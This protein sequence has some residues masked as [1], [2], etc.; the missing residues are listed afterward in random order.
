MGVIRKSVFTSYLLTCFIFLNNFSFCIEI[1]PSK[2][3]R[4]ETLSMT[5]VLVFSRN[6][7]SLRV[8]PNYQLA[9]RWNLFQFHFSIQQGIFTNIFHRAFTDHVHF[10]RLLKNQNKKNWII[11]DIC[12][13]VRCKTLFS[14]SFLFS[15]SFGALIFSWSQF[16][17]H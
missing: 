10:S 16:W 3:R 17:H 2:T 6:G 8:C 12:E 5:F 14:C 7:I 9:K 15:L 11:E 1:I 4:F 13:I